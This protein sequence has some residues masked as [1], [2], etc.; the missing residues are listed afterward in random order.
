MICCS[1]LSYAA[2]SV[3]A[4]GVRLLVETSELLK[5]VKQKNF[6]IISRKE[7]I[8]VWQHQYIYISKETGSCC[9]LGQ[10]IV[11]RN[12]LSA[13][14]SFPLIVPGKALPIW[15]VVACE[16]WG[17]HSTMW[18]QWLAMQSTCLEFSLLLCFC[19]SWPYHA[20]SA[21]EAFTE[22]KLWMG[23]GAWLLLS[24]FVNSITYVPME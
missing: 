13:L 17:S 23:F 11:F 5:K 20:V 19:Y 3:C 24:F 16:G 18:K 12:W 10:I 2:G 7:K 6:K 22:L 9:M 21:R 14:K 4:H 8:K 1:S 15:K